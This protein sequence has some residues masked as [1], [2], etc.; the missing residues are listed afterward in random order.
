MVQILSFDS[1]SIKCI[2]D[3]K[4]HVLFDSEFPV[5]YKLHEKYGVDTNGDGFEDSEKILKHSAIDTALAN[6]QVEATR[7]MLEHVIIHQNSFV[8][9]YLFQENFVQIMEMGIRI[10]GLLQSK[11]FC[12]RFDFSEWPSIHQ[13]NSEIIKPYSGTIFQLRYKYKSIFPDLD[14]EEESSE[15]KICHLYRIIYSL[16]ILPSLSQMNDSALMEA[17][18]NSEE[19]AIFE[20]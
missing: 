9:S 8:Y 6:N 13:D 12:Y 19:L 16:N 10:Q 2:L 3:E 11:I 5:I 15:M 4:H 7:V 14:Q 1:R 17:C 18:G 20:T